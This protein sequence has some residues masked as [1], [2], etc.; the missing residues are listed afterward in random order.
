M[1]RESKAELTDRL[2]REGHWDAFKDRREQL[3]AEGVP[4]SDAWVKAAMEFPPTTESVPVPIRPR[5]TRRQLRSLK[6]KP[7]IGMLKAAQW[8]AENL[9]CDWLRPADAPGLEAWSLREWARTNG[10][11]R[12]EFYRIFGKSLAV[13]PKPDWN[14]F[15]EHPGVAELLGWKG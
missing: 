14:A 10:A 12:S 8:T 5:A 9:D 11:T 4:A 13:I 7:A 15:G 6:R 1:A 3:K 2:R